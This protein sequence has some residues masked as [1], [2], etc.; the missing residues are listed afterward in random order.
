MQDGSS[1]RRYRASAGRVPD[2]AIVSLG[3]TIGLRRAD[4]A[5]AELVREAG[6]ECVVFPVAPERYRRLRRGMLLTD[7]VEAY[8]ARRTAA[9]VRARAIVYSSVTAVLLQ[10]PSRPYAVRFDSPAALNRPG[11]GGR[12]QRRRE[13]AVLS[14]ARLLL[15]WS[16]AAAR[17]ARTRTGALG[18]Y[19]V[20]PPPVE[21]GPVARERDLDAVAYAGNPEKRGLELLCDAWAVAAPAGARLV[22]GGLDPPTATE[23]LRRRGV[24]PPDTV[25]WVGTM[26]HEGWLDLVS[27]ARVF[28]NASRQEEWG[29]AQMEALAAGTPLVTVPSLGPNEAL[30]LARRLAP[31][32]VASGRSAGALATA[33]L[34]GLALTPEAR[35]E[36]ARQASLLLTPYRGES[37]RRIVS[38]Q[39][40]PALLSPE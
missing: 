23:Y 8:A 20:L 37:L 33:V 10:Q 17:A 3:T 34:H 22:V 13:T 21:E 19:V 24:L 35:T 18:P 27:R 36:Y 7:L 6:A 12:W 39:V 30:P 40:L 38:E 31:S 29:L 25:D 2:V 5:L 9:Q 14:S 4:D 28:V 1:A 26:P 11:W 15:P 32:L 16:E